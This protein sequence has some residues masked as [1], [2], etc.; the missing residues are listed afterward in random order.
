MST[1]LLAVELG[2]ND[3]F[4]AIIG[5]L[6]GL[7][8]LLIGFK[9][10]SDNMEKV[11]S[12]GLKKM[13]SSVS[14]SKLAG[15]GIGAA[16]TAIVQS[17]G[18]TTVMIV[19]FVNVGIMSLQQ[20]TAMIMGANIGTTIT[21]HIATLSFLDFG[22]SI[23]VIEIAT[24]LTVI[25]IF[26]NMLAKK[27]VV[28]TVGLILGG[29]GLVFMGLDSMGA[30]M[31]IFSEV[32]AVADLIASANNPFL[33]LLIGLVSTAL[34]QS[35][36]AITSIVISMVGSGLAIG[37]GSTAVLYLVLGTNIGS[38]VT[39]MMS[40]IGASRNAI[41]AGII[42]LMFNVFGSTL[43]FIFLAV[44]DAIA[45]PFGTNF[46]DMTIGL[47]FPDPAQ[48]IAIFHTFFNLVCTALFLPF[49]NLF[50]KL[51]GI[52]VPEKKGQESNL[53]L[54]DERMLKTPAI[55]IEQLYKESIRLADMCMNNLKLAFGGYIKRDESV[56]EEVAK[57]NEEV[58]IVSKSI[59]DY[60]IKVSSG[61]ISMKDESI[62]SI[63]HH[64]LGDIVRIAEMADNFVKY[65][66]REI[67]HNLIFSSGVNEQ[68]EE[69]FRKLEELFD[70][71]KK[72]LESSDISYLAEVDALEEQVDGMRKKLINDHIDRL[73][74]GYC[75]PEN[76]S[77]F[78]NLVSNLERA[79]DHLAYLAHSIEEVK[80]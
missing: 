44:W 6:A 11:A 16:A 30:S 21:A 46:M 29:L 13:F 24:A 80:A 33:L 15:V 69:M 55:A 72:A 50:V 27:D 48:Q 3:Y 47:I 40:V 19:G 73:N 64:N 9:L 52:I 41:R 18:A 26:M 49:T 56:A 71:T 61:D 60:L 39:A 59:T 2:F 43:F 31:K 22:F 68:V 17:S 38:C 45:A 8:A 7:G 58:T 20:A 14:K 28:K 10:L 74:N 12:G 37:S 66:R 51:S 63:L 25:G 65:T 34:I 57:N 54:I 35:S 77:V 70:A 76:S 4:S 62:I 75:K 67:K 32:P 5:L 23:D 79:G 78:I 36:S 1:L 42:H 53:S